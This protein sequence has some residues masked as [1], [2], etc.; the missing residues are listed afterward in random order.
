MV[1]DVVRSC[2]P[3]SVSRLKETR[4]CQAADTPELAHTLFE[5]MPTKV[6]CVMQAVPLDVPRLSAAQLL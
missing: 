5:N 1:T 6:V 4:R 2:M 3:W